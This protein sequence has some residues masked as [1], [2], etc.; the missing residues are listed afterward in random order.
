LSAS[1]FCESLL[2]LANK[3]ST[4]SALTSLEILVALVGDLVGDP[5]GADFE[6]FSGRGEVIS[7]GSGV[8]WRLGIVMFA[9]RLTAAGIV[10]CR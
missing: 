5:S 9:T 2:Q 4:I 1:T 6:D 10:R 8:Y 7:L 3:K